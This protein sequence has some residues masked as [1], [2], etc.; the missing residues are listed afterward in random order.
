MARYN[1]AEVPQ[2]GNGV[3]VSCTHAGEAGRVAEGGDCSGD[4]VACVPGLVCVADVCHAQ[5]DP[6]D[7]QCAQGTCVDASDMYAL[8]AGSIGIC[9]ED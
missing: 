6:T 8:P 3:W 9:I 2:S 7:P 1:F 5:C 4:D